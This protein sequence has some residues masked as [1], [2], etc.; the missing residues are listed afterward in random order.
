ML[1]RF[2]VSLLLAGIVISCAGQ[3]GSPGSKE[4]HKLFISDQTDRGV[5]DSKKP[6]DVPPE[7]M[8]AKD[9]ARRQRAHQLLRQGV[10]QTGEDFH[11]AAFI[12]QH[13]DK[14][15]DY[16]LAHVL[17]MVAVSK[18]DPRGRWIAA[19]TLDRYLQA[20]GQPQ[21]FGTQF[22]QRGYMEFLNQIRAEQVAPKDKPKS[23]PKTELD[24]ASP[25]RENKGAQ[26]AAGEDEHDAK[27]KDEYLQEPYN[28]SLISDSLRA[29]YCVPPIED[30]KARPVELNGG[31]ATARKPLP[32]CSK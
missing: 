30:Q 9:D 4:I 14:P 3:S 17:A 13:G 27:N 12:F 26:R 20:M 32:N 5:F 8:K 15:E 23:A 28:Y 7:Q 6:A 18:G 21:V 25:L 29:Q 2:F 24:S 11:D 10:L 1:K 19:A 16:L 22:A 31:K